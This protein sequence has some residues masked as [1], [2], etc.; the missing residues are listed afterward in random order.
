M[1]RVLAFV[2]ISLLNCSI[3]SAGTLTLQDC[4]EAVA[5]SKKEVKFPSKLDEFTEF[6]DMKCGSELYMGKPTYEYFYKITT[7]TKNQL[8]PDFQKAAKAAI[9]RDTCT[10]SFNSLSEFA[11]RKYIYIDSKGEKVTEVFISSDECTETP[12]ARL[13]IKA[14]TETQENRTREKV[15][16][17]MARDW[18]EVDRV[19]KANEIDEEKQKE[20]FASEPKQ[21]GL[22]AAVAIKEESQIQK[23]VENALAKKDDAT[24]KSYGGKKGSQAY[25]QCRVSLV[26][27]RQEAADRQ[28]T[29]DSLEKKIETLQSQ[30][31]SQAAAQSQAQERDRRL[32]AEQYASEQEF[33]NKQIQ[34]QQEQLQTLQQEA[35]SARSARKWQNIQKSLD[36]MGTVTPAAPS[37]FSSYRIDGR[38]YRCS[39]IGGQV[40]CR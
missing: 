35:Q 10:Q 25:I 17:L 3:A 23:E 15:S 32:S 24:C 29:M 31:Q 26:V 2:A 13:A 1:K 34:L 40:N 36:A 21:T 37:P 6:T 8:R 18:A 22:I 11:N 19:K 7:A 39:D 14:S 27:S 20:R 5:N 28:K 33:K 16:G 12:A 30:I 9:F 4:R 38:T